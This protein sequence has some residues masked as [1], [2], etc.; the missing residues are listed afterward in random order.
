MFELVNKDLKKI[1]IVLFI[2]S[3]FLFFIGLFFKISQIL[4]FSLGIF[5]MLICNILLFKALKKTLYLKLGKTFVFISYIQ[6]Y[7]IYLI[8]LF[9]VYKLSLFFF[10]AKNVVENI[11]FC[12][13]GF[14][15]LQISLY[16]KGVLSY[17]KVRR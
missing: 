15:S 3:I 11:L 13:L 14:L 16:I 2:I 1:F 7:L 5:V 6:R 9:L 10:E 4:F 17:F 12:S 8:T